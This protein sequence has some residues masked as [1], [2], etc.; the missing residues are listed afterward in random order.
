MGTQAMD[1]QKFLTFR[2]R[3]HLTAY[4]PDSYTRYHRGPELRVQDPGEHTPRYSFLGQAVA[5]AVAGSPGPKRNW[6][7]ELQPSGRTVWTVEGFTALLAEYYD[8]T[9]QDLQGIVTMQNDP[10][11]PRWKLAD[12]LVSAAYASAG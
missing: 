11:C 9:D 5:M 1:N 12:R 7:P 10:E 4:L 3:R 8:L 6:V 2:D